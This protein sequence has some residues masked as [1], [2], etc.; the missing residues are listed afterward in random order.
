MTSFPNW[1]M[2]MKLTPFI[3][4]LQKLSIKLFIKFYYKKRITLDSGVNYKLE[5]NFPKVK[6]RVSKSRILSLRST[7][8]V[9]YKE[10]SWDHCDS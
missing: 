9:Y 10:M 1:K 5:N 8:L 4:T 7:S 3:S 6:M 2:E